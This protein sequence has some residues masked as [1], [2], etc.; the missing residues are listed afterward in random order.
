MGNKRRKGI[1]N[2]TMNIQEAQKM[3]IYFINSNNEVESSSYYDFVMESVD[4]TTT[5][6]GVG[7]RVFVENV[8]HYESFYADE[9]IEDNLHELD[10][11]D[12]NSQEEFEQEILKKH[13]QGLR[14]STGDDIIT[15]ITLDH[16]CKDGN[17][18]YLDLFII[19]SWGVGGNNFKRGS[20]FSDMFLYEDNAYNELFKRVEQY[21][22]F[23]DN[24]RDTRFYYSEEEALEALSEQLA[25]EWGVSEETAKS[26]LRR[27]KILDDIRDERTILEKIEN[28][29]I[30]EERNKRISETAKLYAD[31]IQPADESFKDTAKRLSKAIGEK[32]EKDVFFEAVKIIRRSFQK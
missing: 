9:I 11:E 1:R 15:N 32:I 20:H 21:D 2:L 25:E 6:R 4:E 12:Y 27:Q 13:V 17:F 29:R 5:P 30:K 22:F 8:E 14:V 19:S 16:F 7:A 31:L 26:I 10:R 18:Y 28:M 3:T 24:T 23:N